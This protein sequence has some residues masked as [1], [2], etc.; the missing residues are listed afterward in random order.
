MRHEV[1][2]GLRESKQ[3][4]LWLLLVSMAAFAMIWRRYALLAHE[5]SSTILTAANVSVAFA[6]LVSG[7]ISGTLVCQLRTPSRRSTGKYL[8]A[9]GLSP[10]AL[11]LPLGLIRLVGGPDAVGLTSRIHAFYMPMCWMGV[12]VGFWIA[13]LFSWFRGPGGKSLSG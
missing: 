1:G 7:S 3:P 13:N 9:L 12:I 6:G 5:S 8:L 2:G 4:D 10:I 11:F